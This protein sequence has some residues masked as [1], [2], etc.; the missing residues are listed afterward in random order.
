MFDDGTLRLFSEQTAAEYLCDTQATAMW[1][2]IGRHDGECRA[3][4]DML[5][6]LWG[7]HAADVRADMEQWVEA[8]CGS[9]FLDIE[10]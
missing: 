3:A 6:D 4:A 2:A 1:I 8:L 10:S 9:G 7:T 5:A